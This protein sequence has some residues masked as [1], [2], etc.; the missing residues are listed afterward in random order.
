MPFH[1]HQP[2]PGAGAVKGESQVPCATCLT[3]PQMDTAMHTC[4]RFSGQVARYSS[5]QKFESIIGF[6]SSRCKVFRS[7][8][9]LL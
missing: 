7:S 6:L 5:K 1:L 3:P 4:A 2:P 8:L 9:I